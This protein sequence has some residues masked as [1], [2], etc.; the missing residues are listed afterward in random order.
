LPAG[1]GLAGKAGVGLAGKAGVGLAGKAV[2]AKDKQNIK[3]EKIYPF[4]SA[5]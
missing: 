1:V 3:I 5:I 4:F 2:K